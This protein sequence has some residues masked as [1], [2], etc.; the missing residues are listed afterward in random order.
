MKTVRIPPNFFGIAL[1]LSG[2]AALWVFAGASFG[3]P[4]AVGEALRCQHSFTAQRERA[5]PEAETK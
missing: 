2:L 4:A 5:H 3:A 1:G